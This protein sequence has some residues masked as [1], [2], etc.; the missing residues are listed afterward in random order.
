MSVCRKIKEKQFVE[1]HQQEMLFTSNFIRT[2]GYID[3]TSTCAIDEALLNG[4][5]S[6]E[7]FAVEKQSISI[8]EVL[9][10]LRQQSTVKEGR[11][12]LLKSY[13]FLK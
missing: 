2:S 9:D 6:C 5:A 11:Q 12:N 1:L 4:P 13:P 7:L 10:L 8:P 3:K